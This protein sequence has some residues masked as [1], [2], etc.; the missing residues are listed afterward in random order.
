VGGV[1]VDQDGGYDTGLLDGERAEM[2][3]GEFDFAGG[4]GG[5]GVDGVDAGGGLGGGGH[6]LIL[7]DLVDGG[8]E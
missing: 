3:A 1:A 2:V 7:F 5:G 8:V 4:Q 6:G